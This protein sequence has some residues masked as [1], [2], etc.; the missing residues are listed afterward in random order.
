MKSH[1]TPDGY[2]V[3]KHGDNYGLYFRGQLCESGVFAT[4]ATA[5]KHMR[6]A[7]NERRARIER[8]GKGLHL[9]FVH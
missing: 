3:K 8:R 7:E 4:R 1:T 2:T 5:L 9:H 6:I